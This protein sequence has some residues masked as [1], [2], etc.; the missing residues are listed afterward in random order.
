MIETIWIQQV[1]QK[2]MAGNA[3]NNSVISMRSTFS[4]VLSDAETLADLI[5]AEIVIEKPSGA[6]EHK[7]KP[8]E[9][10]ASM[11]VREPAQSVAA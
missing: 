7:P 1:G 4:E 10:T 11:P 5:D 6:I 8:S 3:R 9:L 2:W